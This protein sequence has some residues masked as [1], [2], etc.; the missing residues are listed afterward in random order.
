MGR[1]SERVDA[2]NVNHKIDVDRT[3]FMMK[4][5]ESKTVS[6]SIIN[7]NTAKNS[8]RRLK[9]KGM[10]FSYKNQKELGIYIVTRIE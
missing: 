3:F 10:R 1:N 4:V 2:I 9:G 7:L 5:A 8:F 6:H